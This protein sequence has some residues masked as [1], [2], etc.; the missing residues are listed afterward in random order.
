MD[1]NFL[2]WLGCVL[3]ITGSLLL[4]IKSKYSR[5]AW[6]TFLSSNFCWAGF[7]IITGAYGLIVMQMA[8]TVTSIIGIYTWFIKASMDTTSSSA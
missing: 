6:P 4:A 3:G 8:F 5:W 1:A 7:G 2:E